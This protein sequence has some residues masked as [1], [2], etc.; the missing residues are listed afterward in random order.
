ME[1][2]RKI[3]SWPIGRRLLAISLLSLW[4]IAY[5]LWGLISE[6]ELSLQAAD[7]EIAGVRLIAPIAEAAMSAAL[8]GTEEGSGEALQKAADKQAALAA[9]AGLPLDPDIGS[10]YLASAVVTR[11]PAIAARIAGLTPFA[12]DVVE[13]GMGG[14]DRSDLNLQNS[15]LAQQLDALRVDLKVLPEAK[16]LDSLDAYQAQIQ[17]MLDNPINRKMADS[18]RQAHSNAIAALADFT[19]AGNKQLEG[20]LQDRIDRLHLRLLFSIGTSVAFAAAAFLLMLIVQRRIGRDVGSIAA[21]ISLVRETHDFSRRAEIRGQDDLAQ[22]GAGLN[23]LLEEIGVARAASEEAQRRAASAEA[24]RAHAIDASAA[25]FETAV[26]EVLAGL[27]SG[28]TELQAS[29]TSMADLADRSADKAGSISETAI[30][31]SAVTRDSESATRRLDQAFG[32]IE[33]HIATAED[34][35]RRAVEESRSAE[36][37]IQ[38]LSQQAG[39]IG[40]IVKLIHQLSQQ[41]NLLAL[42]ATIEAARAGEAGKGF[43][44]VAGEVKALADQARHATEEISA[45]IEAIQSGVGVAVQVIHHIGATIAEISTVSTEA[46]RAAGEQRG[47]LSVVGD[48]VR[49]TAQAVTGITEEIAVARDDALETDRAARAMSQTADELSRQ[50]VALETAVR[51]VVE[52]MRGNK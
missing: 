29:A 8:K 2:W 43:A 45:S 31:V 7:R 46:G 4:P 11:L 24:D 18:I 1:A 12:I 37:T 42:N 17:G 21:T 39:K 13:H 52:E 41:T 28:I 33:R 32:Q 25:R 49:R 30:G 10:H 27:S 51:E 20:L 44:V 3:G 23:E 14:D 9:E 22:M 40:E 34:S 48:G 19:A 5:L 16:I 26:K 36:S 38:S 50:A 35:A 6:K 15:G 47:V